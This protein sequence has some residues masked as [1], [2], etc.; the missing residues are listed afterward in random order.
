MTKKVVGMG[1]EKSHSDESE[2]LVCS[3]N[4]EY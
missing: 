1:Y 3:N 4:K 2:W